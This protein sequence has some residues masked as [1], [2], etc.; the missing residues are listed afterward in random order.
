MAKKK[1][2][3]P[4]NELDAMFS[5]MADMIG[6]IDDEQ[7]EMLQG[8]FSGEL[9]PDDQTNKMFYRYERPDY[10]RMVKPYGNWLLPFKDRNPEE[11]RV[12]LFE[13]VEAAGK[14]LSGEDKLLASC[15]RSCLELAVKNGIRRL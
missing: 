8:M 15:Y 1:D 6:Q 11:E 13:R 2:K 7:M 4:R 5:N 9:D 10:S 14:D 12:Q 3:D